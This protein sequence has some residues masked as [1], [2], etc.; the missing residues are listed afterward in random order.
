MD[1]GPFTTR[2]IEEFIRRRE[3]GLQ[4]ELKNRRGGGW[5]LMGEIPKL[6]Q[7]HDDMLRKEEEAR[8]HAEMMKG[9]VAV[10]KSMAR[11]GASV[12]V[13]GG[14]AFGV[15]L[16]LVAYFLLRTPDEVR[17]GIP[18]SFFRDLSFE[19]LT[20]YKASEVAAMKKPEATAE[21]VTKPIAPKRIRRPAGSGTG[22]GTGA[23]GGADGG[24]GAPVDISFGEEDTSGGRALSA[25]DLS[26]VG[27]RVTPALIRC[28]RGEVERN[29][30]FQGG[31][32]KLYVM[33]SG[34]V[35]VASL[36][37]SPSPS[38]E[39]AACAR[40][41]VAGTRVPPFAGSTQVMEIPLHVAPL[42]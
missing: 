36:A 30:A 3:I 38:G 9:V 22:A 34:T 6:R 42:K 21:S 29:A 41:A 39:L 12:L 31:S 25:E 20:L 40:S 8:Q 32:V 37:T 28:F 11:R 1:Y 13:V 2:D 4:T 14:I 16:G 17:Q 7:F 27:K 19:R 15:L 24:E 5:A 33:P 26:G 10:E 35:S 18:S 23:E